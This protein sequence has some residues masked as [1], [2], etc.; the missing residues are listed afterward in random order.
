[1]PGSTTKSAYMRGVRDGMPF[2]I[3]LLPF[4]LL[5]GVVATEAGLTLT[6]TMGFNVLV[7]AG[8]AQ[9]AAVALMQENAPLFAVLTTALAVN[10]RMGMYS[11]ALV[12]HFGAAPFW[13]RAC[14]AYLCVDQ[15][16]AMSVLEYDKRPDMT[17]PEKMAFFFGVA[18]PLIPTWYGV[19]LIGVVIGGSIPPALALDFALPIAFISMVAPSL[20]TLAHLAAALTSVVVALLLSGLP[21]GMGLL[22]AAASAMAV[23][24]TVETINERRA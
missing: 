19:A 1:M 24:A 5:F 8:S 2:V 23:G 22:I 3:V 15:T 16:Y 4:A 11:A 21:W 17:V 6:Q 14:A 9:F 13:K 12:P 18:T 20:R 10:L 7:I